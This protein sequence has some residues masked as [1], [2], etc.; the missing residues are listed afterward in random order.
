M[1]RLKDCLPRG[2]S[3]DAIYV[4]G[5]CLAYD[6]QRLTVLNRACMEKAIQQMQAGAKHL[7]FSG[8]YGG[9]VLERELTLR[10]ELARSGG[11]R[12]AKEISGIVDTDDELTKLALVLNE[13]G[14]RSVIL[15][16]DEYHIPRLVRW[17]QIKLPG[18]EIFHIS[19]RAPAYEFTW[20]PSMIKVV[21]SGIKPL[22]ILWNVLLYMATSLLLHK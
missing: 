2:G 1:L 22:W 13:L 11:V 19:V 14:A 15:V 5:L 17:A 8:C 12:N 18:V 6:K 3:V 20:E 9:E 10:R 4:P 21:R 7:V 16:S